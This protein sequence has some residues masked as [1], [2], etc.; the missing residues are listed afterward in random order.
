MFL[1]VIKTRS[2]GKATKHE[3]VRVVEAYR[4]HNGKTQHRT[5]INL[6]RRDLLAAHLD[7]GKLGRLLHG[8]ATHTDHVKLKAWRRPKSPR[9]TGFEW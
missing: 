4:D 8:D 6:G 2:G 9:K 1:R 7:L 3:Y 5:I